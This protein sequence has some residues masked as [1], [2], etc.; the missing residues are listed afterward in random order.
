[1]VDVDISYNATPFDVREAHARTM[2]A[3]Q[4]IAA[5]CIL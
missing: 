4:H 2:H 5:R 3:V 1:M